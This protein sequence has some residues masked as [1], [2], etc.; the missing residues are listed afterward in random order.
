MFLH[1]FVRFYFRST[2]NLFY[3]I[4]SLFNAPLRYLKKIHLN[5]FNLFLNHP[6][7]RSTFANFMKTYINIDIIPMRAVFNRLSI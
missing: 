4:L 6:E 2:K 3:R 7:K 1:R 5:E